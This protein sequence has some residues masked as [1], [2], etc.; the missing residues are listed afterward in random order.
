MYEILSLKHVFSTFQETVWSH[1]RYDSLLKF[2][3]KRKYLQ[4]HTCDVNTTASSATRIIC[5]IPGFIFI[6]T[7]TSFT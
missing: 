2:D 1:L 3:R 5:F 6:P 4:Q 7:A